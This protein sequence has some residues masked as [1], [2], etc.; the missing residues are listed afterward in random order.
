MK[1][2]ESRDFLC[3][4]KLI[5][6]P[7][8]DILYQ[9][10]ADVLACVDM[11]VINFG[12]EEIEM[13]FHVFS[14]LRVIDKNNILMTTSDCFFDNDFERLSSQR[15]EYERNN[16]YKGTLLYSNI[17]RVKGILKDAKVS[18]AYS[19]DI[20]DV[21]IEFDNS[22]IMEIRIDA[23]CDQECYRFIIYTEDSSQHNVVECKKRQIYYELIAD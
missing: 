13:S 10:V 15:E 23:L 1:R 4:K 2:F 16:L 7:I 6:K 11:F 3:I 12:Y 9:P 22:V 19:T 17:E 5:G 14:F 20:G 8:K 21:I 18:K